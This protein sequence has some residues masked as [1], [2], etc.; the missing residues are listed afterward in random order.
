MCLTTSIGG[1]GLAA[2][3]AQP[4]GARGFSRSAHLNGDSLARKWEDHKTRPH[5]G[6][7]TMKT[8]LI[9]IAIVVLLL[10][11]VPA[12]RGRRRL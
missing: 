1:P 7:A 3:A 6:T 12:L 5:E 10:L 9:I 2:S 8:L 4:I 11:V